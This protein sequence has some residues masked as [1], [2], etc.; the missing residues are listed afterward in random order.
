VDVLIA[1]VLNLWALI[2]MLRRPSWAFE[3]AE[4]GRL[5][6]LLLLVLSWV[7]GI[8]IFIAIWYLMMVSPRIRN[9]QQLG[10]GPGFPGTT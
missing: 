2:D 6:W 1:F 9:Q 7:C 5:T 4:V 10:R 3:Q 8:G